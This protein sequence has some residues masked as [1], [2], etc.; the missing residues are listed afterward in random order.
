MN[1]PKQPDRLSPG[2]LLRRARTTKHWSVE[3]ISQ[4]LKLPT[5]I[6]KKIE[7]DQCDLSR[8]IYQRGYAVNYARLLDL[9][10]D[11]F[12]KVL[13]EKQEEEVPLSNALSQQSQTKPSE[14]LLTYATYFIGTVVVA[15]PLVWSLTD[16]AA[17]FFTKNTLSGEPTV[18]TAPSSA[19]QTAG[20]T[21]QP[22]ADPSLAPPQHAHMSASVAPL[23]ALSARA[24]S[25]VEARSNE[26]AGALNQVETN[27]NDAAT[28]SAVSTVPPENLVDETSVNADAEPNRSES[29]TVDAATLDTPA[30][31]ALLVSMPTPPLRL[32]LQSDSWV[33]ITDASGRRLE[34][35]LVHGGSTKDYEGEAPY[36][37]LIG[38]A[39]GVVLEHH[40]QTVDLAPHIRGNVASFELAGN[41]VAESSV[42]NSADQ[43]E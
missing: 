3:E 4:R 38:S 21:T 35:D 11:H 40:G 1:Q 31:D 32:S 7:Q 26:G 29:V 10:L 24:S 13:G 36:R 34:Y 37:I 43:P 8:D 9:D 22:M 25:D 14:R 17:D 39:T 5:A 15:I 16:G 18:A 6:V 2:Q 28:S 42:Q 20:Q 27:A 41:P 19:N 30:E 12:N 23:G 33:E